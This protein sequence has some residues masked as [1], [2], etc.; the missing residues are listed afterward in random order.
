[1]VSAFFNSLSIDA[2][3]LIES[4]AVK[5]SFLSVLKPYSL[6]FGFPLGLLITFEIALKTFIKIKNVN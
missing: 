4:F 3:T 2:V 5:G 6:I 1:M